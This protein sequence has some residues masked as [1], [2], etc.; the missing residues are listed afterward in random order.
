MRLRQRLARLRRPSSTELAWRARATARQVADRVTTAVR[1]PAWHR[2]AL[3]RALTPVG[4]IRE[5]CF[6]LDAGRIDDAN[7]ALAS[8]VQRRPVRFVV[9]PSMRESV[10]RRVLAAWSGAR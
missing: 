1:P 7:R 6:L 8:H 4:E 9:H 10:V 3:A 2:P 5:I